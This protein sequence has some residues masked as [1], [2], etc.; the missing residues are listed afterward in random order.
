MRNSTLTFK[1]LTHLNV[2]KSLCIP[3][4]KMRRFQLNCLFQIS[5]G[6]W[7][8]FL[9]D[10]SKTLPEISF[11][12]FGIQFDC[13]VECSSSTFE[14]I[15]QHQSNSLANVCCMFVLVKVNGFLATVQA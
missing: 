9:S 2:S 1:I 6:F 14:I 15:F 8:L 3:S 13:T 12:I 4:I 7:K 5:Y 11:W 10:V